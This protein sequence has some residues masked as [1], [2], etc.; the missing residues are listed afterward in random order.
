MY[1]YCET[2]ELAVMEGGT[3]GIMTAYNRLNGEFCA[4]HETLLTKILREEWGFE[5]F[6]VTDWFSAGSTEGSAQ[7]GLDLQMPGPGRYFGSAL[8]DAVKEGRLEESVLDDQVRR[9]LGVWNRIGALDD[10]LEGEEQSVDRPEHRA[11]AKEAAA[12]SMVLLKN[13]GVLPLKREGLRKL[14]VIGPNA[15]RA[16]IMGG[17]SAALRAHYRVTPLE[18]LSEKLGPDV[19]IVHAR[20]CWT[21]KTTPAISLI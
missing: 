2:F 16:Q 8:A 17:G 11:I 1:T 15:D 21:E 19:E 12:D 14:A 18:A 20:G 9:M 10:V 7:A 3:L 6:V 13:E 4:E 5:G